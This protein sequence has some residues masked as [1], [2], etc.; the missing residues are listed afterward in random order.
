MFQRRDFIKTMSAGALVAASPAIFSSCTNSDHSSVDLISKVKMAMLTMQR[1]SWEQGVAMQALWEIGDPELAYLMA[2]EAVLRQ[3]G[4]GRLS[5]LYSDNGVTDPAA[6]GEVVF[7]LAKLNNDQELLDAHQ[8]MIGYLLNEA[9]KTADGILHH[10]VNSPEIW[11]DSFYMAPPYL[12]VAGYPAEAIKQI[13][14][15]RH[16]LWN[17]EQ[18]LYSHRWH[19]T[20]NRFLNEKFWGVGNGWA[21]AGLARIID[22]LPSQMESDRQQLITFAIENINGCLKYLRTDGLF[23]NIVNDSTSFVETNLSQMLAYSIFRGIHS[24]WLGEEYLAKAELMRN[25][26]HLKVDEFGYVQGACGAP[27]FNATGRAT[28]SQAFFLLMEAAYIKLN[29]Q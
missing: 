6:S 22:D 26:A 29:K 2:K 17:A 5:V 1:A 14:G 23:H 24:G 8:K 20:E 10:T 3:A 28:E 11:V 16:Y 27:W 9:P 12:C 4:D 25:A 7:Q 21:I 19:V 15:F 13:N 18:N